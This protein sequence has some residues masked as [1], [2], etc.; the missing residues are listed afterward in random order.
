MFARGGGKT[1][2]FIFKPPEDDY[3]S[4]NNKINADFAHPLCQ[5]GVNSSLKCLADKWWPNNPSFLD[6][7]FGFP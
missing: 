4:I 1:L 3:Y 7:H 2:L 5:R 6:H